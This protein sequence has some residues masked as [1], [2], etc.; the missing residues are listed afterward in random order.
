MK[1]DKKYMVE[2]LNIDEHIYI[3]ETADGATMHI[4]RKSQ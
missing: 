2:Y 4:E 3:K 1:K